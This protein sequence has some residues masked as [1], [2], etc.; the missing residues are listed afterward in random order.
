MLSFLSLSSLT[1]NRQ[2][3]R[4]QLAADHLFTRF[5]LALGSCHQEVKLA[6]FWLFALEFSKVI[7]GLSLQFRGE[8]AGEEVCLLVCL[9]CCVPRF[10]RRSRKI[11]KVSDVIVTWTAGYQAR[12]FKV[13]KGCKG[14]IL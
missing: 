3:K 11:T 14:N 5:H 1:L 10:C 6:D 7:C 4:R 12:V 2:V 13:C 8:V 9:S